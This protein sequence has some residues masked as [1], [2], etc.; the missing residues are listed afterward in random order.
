MKKLLIIGPYPPLY[1]YG[2]PTRSVKGLYETLSLTNNCKVL[3][4]RSHLFGKK[5]NS[6]LDENNDIIYSDRPILYIIFNLSKG[7]I[8][9]FNSFFEIKLLFLII[10]SKIINFKIVVSPR[11]QLSQE[12]IKT[13]NSF[14]KKLFIK[15]IKIISSKVTFHS[16]DSNETNDISKFYKKNKV[17]NIKNI[18]S[19]NQHPNYIIQP[20]FVFYSRIHKKKGLDILLDHLIK[21]KIDVDLDIYGFIEDKSYWSICKSKIEVLKTVNYCGSISDGDISVLKNKY[22]FFIL[23]TLNE[24]FGHVIVELISLGI[25]PIISKGT[26]PFDD[27]INSKIGLNFELTSIKDFN[28]VFSMIYKLKKHDKE[29]LKRNV[30]ELYKILDNNQEVIK[31]DYLNLVKEL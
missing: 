16:T 5:V 9:W 8:V 7:D 4:P 14:T 21:T 26:T 24:N 28:R 25:I 3:S 18:F 27:L 23:P 20:K 15:A 31:K 11:G 17:Y 19:L 13:S 6:G 10:Y 2:G 30:E 29:S 1:S 22:S 12:A